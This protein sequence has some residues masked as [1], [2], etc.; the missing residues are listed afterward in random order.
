[1]IDREG[2]SVA[3]EGVGPEWLHRPSADPV[4]RFASCFFKQLRDVD[5]SK[6]SSNGNSAATPLLLSA[7]VEFPTLRSLNL[8]WRHLSQDDCRRLARLK[9]LEHLDLTQTGV[10][11]VGLRELQGLPRLT[12][13]SLAGTA[14]DNDGVGTL[15]SFPQLRSV[16]LDDT[17]I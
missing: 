6:N 10:T 4:T 13:L 8:S 7:L 14:I 2:G 1:A 16:A 11:D 17:R 9:G 5:L 15:R 3:L 12:S